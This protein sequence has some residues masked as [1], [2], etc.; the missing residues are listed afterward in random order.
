LHNILLQALLK[1]TLAEAKPK[2]LKELAKINA[3]T[4]NYLTRQFPAT[5]TNNKVE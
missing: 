5:L 3:M 2:L 1:A 4:F